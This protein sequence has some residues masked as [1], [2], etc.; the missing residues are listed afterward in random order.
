MLGVLPLVG[1]TDRLPARSIY[2]ASSG[3]NALSC[4]GVALS[5]G[6]LPALCFRGLAGVA[7]AGMYMPGL[8][9]LT[10]GTE[11]AKRARIAGYYTSSFTVG[12]SLSFLLGQAAIEWG[13]RGTFIFAGILGA[14]GTLVAR[15]ALPPHHAVT[16]GLRGSAFPYRRVLTDRDVVV[17]VC[18]YAAVIWGSVGLRQWIVAFLGFCGAAPAVGSTPD[19]TMLVTGAVIGLLGVPAGLLGNELSIRFEL[20]NT[21]LF[22]FLAAAAA[23]GAY[24]LTA[25]LP[26]SAAVAVSLAAGFIVQGNFSNLTAGLLVVAARKRTGAIIAVYSCIGFAGGFVGNILF[27]IAFD[28]FGG[29]SQIT[30][31]VVSFATCAMAGLIGAGAAALLSRNADLRENW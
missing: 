11:G 7:L 24:G 10:E 4:F 31:W 22:M 14:A 28:L 1:A 2:I 19:W 13:W 3:L 25:L 23:N 30:A 12:A 15:L 17:L 8:R 29:T 5:D 16:E 9:A 26:Y 27:G 6:V 18:G 21:A 20:R